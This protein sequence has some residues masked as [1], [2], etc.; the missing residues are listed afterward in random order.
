MKKKTKGI[1]EERGLERNTRDE[2]H[3]DNKPAQ[4]KD[5]EQIHTQYKRGQKVRVM[6]TNIQH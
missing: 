1:V 6:Y 5:P 3:V 2:V 4:K